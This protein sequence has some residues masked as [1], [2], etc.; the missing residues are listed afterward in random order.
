MSWRHILDS[1]GTPCQF[2]EGTLFHLA[3]IP[4][5]FLSGKLIMTN[6]SIS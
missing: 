2:W 4:G 3:T 5:A 1:L 6:K